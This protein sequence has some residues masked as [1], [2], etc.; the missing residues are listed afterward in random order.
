MDAATLALAKAYTNS[1][2]LAYSEPEKVLIEHEI[3]S[4]EGL[5]FGLPL[6][7][8]VSGKKYIVTLFDGV[9]SMSVEY[10]A[11]ELHLDA[12]GGGYH[13]VYLGNPGILDGEDNGGLFLVASGE[14]GA[15]GNCAV[16]GAAK[17]YIK[18]IRVESP[19]TIHP[20]DPKYLPEGS[21]GYTELAKT[22][23][24]TYDQYQNSTAPVK[25][26]MKYVKI[27][28]SPLSLD[29]LTEF[30]MCIDPA[31]AE[32]LELPE[33]V[34]RHSEEFE[35]E[36]VEYMQALTIDGSVV[37]QSIHGNTP[38]AGQQTGT[39]V[40]SQVDGDGK[41]IVWLTDFKFGEDVV[42]PIDPKY[43]PGG[44]SVVT[45][46]LENYGATFDNGAYIA[47]EAYERFLNDMNT[48]YA[49]KQHVLLR[50]FSRTFGVNATVSPQAFLFR[51]DG[52]FYTLSL[53]F[54]TALSGNSIRV[55]SIIFDNQSS[56]EILIAVY[57]NPVET[58]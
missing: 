22:I 36:N 6:I 53:E 20:I 9:V 28:D 16:V 52:T 23:K 55:S 1:Q 38:G 21:V 25:D 45:I 30:T 31:F 56:G 39:Y 48:A 50:A 29:R 8:L 5:D 49:K 7:D 54:F 42:H 27:S 17:S 3:V 37:I 4:E 46:D 47:G 40:Q 18:K 19:E 51:E 10:E 13:I 15:D 2:R 57:T 43:L 26:G 24:V 34:V 11:M 41:V 12:D 32:E 44:G 14:F 35:L 58:T 33:R